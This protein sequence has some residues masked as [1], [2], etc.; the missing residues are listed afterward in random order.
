MCS[1]IH[2]YILLERLTAFVDLDYSSKFSVES[3]ANTKLHGQMG[4]PR[5]PDFKIKERLKVKT[6]HYVGRQMPQMLYHII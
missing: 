5:K 1:A 3:S 6:S 4:N 2:T